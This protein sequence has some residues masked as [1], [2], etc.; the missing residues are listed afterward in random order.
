MTKIISKPMRGTWKEY[1]APA[2]VVIEPGDL[3]YADAN[4]VARPASS[5]AD[6]ATP[7]TNYSNFATAF[8][9]VAASPRRADQATEGTVL[10]QSA[11]Y[12]EYV[13][14]PLKTAATFKIGDTVGAIEADS[15]TALEDKLVAKTTT[16]NQVIGTVVKH[17]ASNTSRVLVKL[18]K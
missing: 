10:V 2:S 7:A 1:P 13:E 16:A 5:Q 18:A 3:L 17:Y 12:G 8:I 4:G 11:D 15:G 9:G 14:L 6:T